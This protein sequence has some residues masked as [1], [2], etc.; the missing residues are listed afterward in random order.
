MR[1]VERAKHCKNPVARDLFLLMENKK[2]N[3]AIAAD[4]T[5]SSELLSLADLLGPEICV[6]KTHIDILKDFTPK[7]TDELQK[8][9]QKHQFMIFED[10]KFADIGFTVWEQYKGGIY[11][12]ANWADIV[13]AHIIPGPGIIEG[14]REVGLPKKRG[15]LLLAQ[16]SSEG[17]LAH[18]DYTEKAVAMAEQYPDFVMGFISQKKISNNPAFIHMTPGV[19]IGVEK[20]HL[21]QQYRTPEEIINLGNDIMIVGRGI[22]KGE[23]PREAAIQYR[24]RGWKAYE[25]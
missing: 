20:D 12:I 5:S 22:I 17:S 19:Q 8:I 7:L 21:G 9:A 16:M 3:L 18:G 24:E 13:N 10:R 14:L 1:H 23:N 25:G 15:L 2:T 6:F 4:V 11:H